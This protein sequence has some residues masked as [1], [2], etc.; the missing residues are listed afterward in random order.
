MRQF[1]RPTNAPEWLGEVLNSIRGALSDEWPTPLRL[2]PYAFADVPP[3]AD[4]AS[5]MAYI[6]GE[7]GG[8]VPAFSDGTSWR[9][10]TDRKVIAAPAVIANAANTTVTDLG[11]GLYSIQ[12]TGGVHLS[13]DASA[14]SSSALTGDF[15]IQLRAGSTTVGGI[16]GVSASPTTDND[17]D[18][19][20]R[21]LF[22]N[23][24]AGARAYELGVETANVGAYTTSQYWFIRRVGTTLTL[25]KGASDIIDDATVQHTFT[26]MSGSVY[27]D[28][29]IAV[30]LQSADARI[31]V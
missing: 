12:K 2:A 14:V 23:D 11:A 25:L 7:S 17:Y 8:S 26:A 1:F 27:F 6:T 16:F 15:V 18:T 31:F 9:R 28:S 30:S 29:S 5:G 10:V 4:W 21:G 24:T 19:I 13:Y 3:A 22:F 20:D